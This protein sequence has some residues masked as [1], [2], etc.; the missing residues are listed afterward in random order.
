MAGFPNQKEEHQWPLLLR[1]L[2]FQEP[3][4]PWIRRNL[5]QWAAA[6]GLPVLEASRAHLEMYRSSME[7]RGLAASTI[8]RRLSTACGF[9]RFAHIDGRISSNPAQYD[10]RPTVHLSERRGL[11]RA[12]L[13]R[14]LFSAERFDHAHAALAVLLGRNGLRVSEACETN[15]EDMAYERGHRVLRIIGKGNKPAVIPLVPRTARTI[16]LAVGRTPRRPDSVASRWTAPRSP[17][18]SQ[19]GALDR[20]AGRNRLGPSPHAQSCVHYGRPRRRSPSP[21]SSTRC[22]P[23]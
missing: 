3:T 14:F 18:R 23:R 9:Y 17:H 11:D 6:H 5:F 19:L 2:S 7:A 12:A 22:P 13:G 8:D 15:I 16:D 4:T 10:R 20:Q 21:R 1:P